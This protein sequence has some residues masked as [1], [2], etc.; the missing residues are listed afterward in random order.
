[1]F[2]VTM[3][4]SP[5]MDSSCSSGLNGSDPEQMSE[6]KRMKTLPGC[7]RHLE[8]CFDNESMYLQPYKNAN[9]SKLLEHQL[10]I[11]VSD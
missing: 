2:H 8:C 11:H 9:T 6:Q 7:R 5:S 3:N 10:L 4:I 1:M